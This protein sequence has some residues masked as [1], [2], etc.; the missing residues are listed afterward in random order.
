[1]NFSN[2]IYSIPSILTFKNFCYN[3]FKTYYHALCLHGVWQTVPI[4]AKHIIICYETSYSLCLTFLL[5][6]VTETH[7]G[8]CRY[9]FIAPRAT[10][11]CIAPVENIKYPR[12]STS[13]MV[14]PHPHYHF[15][16]LQL[17]TVVVVLFN[18]LAKNK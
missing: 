5:L 4:Q 2:I 16:I 9:I 13:A 10:C 8:S 6:N 7:L 3:S 17:C 18:S 1:M 15:A 12:L 11:I 14:W